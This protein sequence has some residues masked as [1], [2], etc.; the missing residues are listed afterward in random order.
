MDEA[1]LHRANPVNANFYGTDLA[2]ARGFAVRGKGGLL[3]EV[4]SIVEDWVRERLDAHGV[5]AQPGM[6][7]SPEM[8]EE[9]PGLVA[10][11][12]PGSSALLEERLHG[13]AGLKVA[14]KRLAVRGDISPKD[15]AVVLRIP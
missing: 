1:N 4:H 14:Y 7:W 3:R 6:E 10:G 5:Y 8:G 2:G 15:V 9:E 13:G 11:R 12:V